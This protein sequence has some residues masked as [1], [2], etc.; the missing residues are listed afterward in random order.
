MSVLR[1]G[2]RVLS[3]AFSPDGDRIVTAA[4]GGGHASIWDAPTVDRS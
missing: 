2:G 3:A 4:Y 1:A